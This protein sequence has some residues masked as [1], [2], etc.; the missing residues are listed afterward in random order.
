MAAGEYVSVRPQADT[1][2]ADM[3]RG[4]Q[5]L[6]EQPEAEL[7]ELAGIYVERGLSRELAQ[8]GCRGN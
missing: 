7:A 5:E 1:E 2:V 6:A 3:A 8:K 4:R